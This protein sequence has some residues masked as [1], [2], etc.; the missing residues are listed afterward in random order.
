MKKKNL[1]S[2]ALNKKSISTLG[3]NVT[4]GALPTSRACG[5]ESEFRCGPIT[6]ETIC[7]TESRDIASDCWCSS[8]D[9]FNC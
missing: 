5:A 3:N 2:L 8:D 7:W 9:S 4:A 6:I 1:K